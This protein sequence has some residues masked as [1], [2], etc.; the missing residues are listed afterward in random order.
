M[1]DN[2]TVPLTGSGDTTAAVATDDV[3]GVHYQKIKIALGADGAIDTL[4]DSGQQTGANSIPVVLASDDAAVVALQIIDDWD[5]A[6]SDGA[7]VSGDVAHD[8]ADAGEPVKI[9]M[10]AVAHS[11]NPTA[12]TANDRT[13][14]Y[15]NRHGIPFVLGGHMN[16][17]SLELSVTTAVTDQAII[18]V[19]GGTKIVVTAVR[20]RADAANIQE[21]QFR[22]GF[23]AASTPTTTGVVES[24]PGVPAGSGT[25]VGNGGG[26]LGVGADGEDL[27]ITAENPSTEIRVIVT[28]FTIES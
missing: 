14:W 3:G 4:V 9:G 22:I 10:K 6:A 19:S 13:N 21:P 7:S 27:R 26:M 23:G 2:V 28:Y 11:T 8:T 5:N 18:T 20:A 24:H 1:A 15:A 12:V 17:I 16:P 25:G